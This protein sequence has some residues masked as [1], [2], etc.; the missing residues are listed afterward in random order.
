[1]RLIQKGAPGYGLVQQATDTVDLRKHQTFLTAKGKTV[2]REIVR[3]TRSDHQNAP[4][5]RAR[6]RDL[7][8]AVE[9][10]PRDLARDQWLPRLLTAGRKLDTDDIELAVRQ[11]EALIGHRESKRLRLSRPRK[12]NKGGAFVFQTLLESP[13]GQGGHRRVAAC[14]HRSPT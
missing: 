9:R 10:S 11:I 4:K 8:T 14:V 7:L 12:E 13:Y 3:L 1:L 2:M 6:G 5:L